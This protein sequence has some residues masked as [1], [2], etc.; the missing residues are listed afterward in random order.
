MPHF[1]SAFVLPSRQSIMEAIDGLYSL[2]HLLIVL[3]I[4]IPKRFKSF[5]KN[6]MNNIDVSMNFH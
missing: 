5:G 4:L 2:L 6:E 3:K 1:Y